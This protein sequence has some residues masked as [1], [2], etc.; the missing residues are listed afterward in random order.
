VNN[1]VGGYSRAFDQ[2]S[3]EYGWT[4]EMILDITVRRLRQILETIKERHRVRKLERDMVTEW[5]TKTLAGFI[6]NTIPVP[7][8]KSNKLAK[9]VDNIRLVNQE[10]LKRA[11]GPQ[12]QE[13]DPEVF[14]EEGSQVAEERNSRG[15]WE[16][17]HQGFR[18][19]PQQ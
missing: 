18:E 19:V 4:D 12:G 1:L 8:G 16:A 10:D 3:A 15:S 14:V 2:I 11:A 13:A 5:Q 17:I 9:E 6:A 7:K